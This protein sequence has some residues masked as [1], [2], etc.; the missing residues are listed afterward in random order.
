MKK[1]TIN[2]G[3]VDDVKDGKQDKKLSDKDKAEG[4]K[5]MAQIASGVASM[6]SKRK[7]TVKE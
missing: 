2:D 6:F 7:K 1:R 3:D 4:K 5:K